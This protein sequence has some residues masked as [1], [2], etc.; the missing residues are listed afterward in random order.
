VI[1][2]ALNDYYQMLKNNEANEIPREEYSSADVTFE[3]QIDEFGFVQSIVPYSD[4][5]GKSLKRSYNVP[6]QAKRSSGIHPYFLC[7]KAE[8]YFGSTI[9]LRS[10]C[11]ESMRELVQSILKFTGEDTATIRALKLFADLT[12]EQLSEQLN[13]FM[14]TSLQDFLVK[15]GLGVI[16]FA[17]TGQYLHQDQMIQNAWESFF[18]YE[19]NQE[20]SE[21][22]QICL[23][24]GELLP[25]NQIARLHPSIKNVVGAQSSGAAIVSFN[26][27]SFCSFGRKQSHNAPTSKQA[28]EAYGYV[29]NR[30]LS[31]KDHKIRMNDTTVVFWAQSNSS[32]EQ[33]LLSSLFE[34]VQAL[35]EGQ[36]HDADSIRN[37]VRNAMERVRNGQHFTE[38]FSDIDSNLKYYILGLSPNAARLS[39]RFWYSGTIAEIGNRVWEHY[40]DLSVVGLHHSPTIKEILRELAVGHDWDNIPPNMEGQLLRSILL[41]QSYSRT[42]FAQLMNRIRAES[43]DPKKGLFKIGG[44]RAAII[45]AYLKRNARKNK[46]EFEEGEI[47][48]S[49]NEQSTSVAYQLGRLFACLEKTQSDAL[50]QGI[51]ATIKDRFWGAASATPANIFP[52]LLSLA[53]H[54]VAKDEKWGRSN[55]Q[56]IQSVMNCLQEQFPRRLSLE[57]QGKFA[58]GY[59]QQKQDMYTKKSDN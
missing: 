48:V 30:F 54:H 17:P 58:L 41:G 1:L 29:L 11:R 32:K 35:D 16:K 20:E 53:Q 59:Y 27:D 31:S 8:Y 51:N 42:I 36:M 15:G 37:R 9:G 21:G 28:A 4:E 50:G 43:D 40:R 10:K 45:K 24:S 7:D 3:L 33:D 38:I 18:R 12:D 13:R 2:Q 52:R 49:L 44:V 19:S 39:V 47:T 26:I 14:D 23:I 22:N 56:R 46:N 34:D 57:D 6:K 55:D 25:S 5:K